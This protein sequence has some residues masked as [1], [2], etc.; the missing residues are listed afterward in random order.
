MVQNSLTETVLSKSGG[1]YIKTKDAKVFDGEGNFRFDVMYEGGVVSRIPLEQ[2]TA[3]GV[4]WD[5]H[6]ISLYDAPRMMPWREAQWYCRNLKLCGRKTSLG[7]KDFWKKLLKSN[8]FSALNAL[9]I[10][11]GGQAVKLNEWYW[12]ID[13]NR[14]YAWAWI[15]NLSC[16][17]RYRV[18]GSLYVRPV[19][20][21]C[22]NV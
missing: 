19:A 21:L 13:A 5:G 2:L 18:S 9:I 8:R 4:L 20:L 1:I 22:E 15:L 7:T 11:L 10:H 6:L 12:T 16:F 3:V 17:Y 14:L